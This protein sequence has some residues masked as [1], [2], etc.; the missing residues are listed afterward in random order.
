MTKSRLGAR[1]TK[2][3]TVYADDQNED[4]IA[5]PERRRRK[6]T[7][8]SDGLSLEEGVCEA[9]SRGLPATMPLTALFDD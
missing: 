8:V 2:Q 3:P 5:L 9:M 1:S 4:E 6:A 7:D